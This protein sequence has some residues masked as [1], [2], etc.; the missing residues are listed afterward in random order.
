MS[1]DLSL[2]THVSPDGRELWDWAGRI[3]QAIQRQDEMDRLRRKIRESGRCGECYHWMHSGDCPREHN[4]NGYSRGPHMDECPCK[5]F[6]WQ[7]TYKDLLEKR[8]M[9]L[10]ALEAGDTP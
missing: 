6:V 8:K 5:Q 2:P 4:V 3:G 1:D 10:A 7:Q 9:E